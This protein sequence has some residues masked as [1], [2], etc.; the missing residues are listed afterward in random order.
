MIMSYGCSNFQNENGKPKK[1]NYFPGDNDSLKKITS[2]YFDISLPKV[3]VARRLKQSVKFHP[4][5]ARKN[6]LLYCDDLTSV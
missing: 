4:S 3:P 6:N 2:S 1:E 5:R